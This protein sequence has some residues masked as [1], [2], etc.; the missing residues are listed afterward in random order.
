MEKIDNNQYLKILKKEN[1][2]LLAKIE[3]INDIATY[4]IEKTVDL[5]K[6][7]IISDKKKV[8]FIA[9]IWK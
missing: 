5:E 9:K 6:I 7:R 1:N 2:Y 8:N 4:A 3:Q